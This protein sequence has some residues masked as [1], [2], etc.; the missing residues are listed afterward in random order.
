MKDD[1]IRA[2]YYWLRD[3]FWIIIKRDLKKSKNIL[4]S[5]PDI[6]SEEKT[7]LD[8]VSLKINLRDTMYVGGQ[9]KQYLSVGISA[10]RCIQEALKNKSNDFKV[11]SV[12][13]FAG[14]SGRVLRFLKV[15][16]PNADIYISEL[17]KNALKFCNKHLNVK[18]FI[19]KIH[20]NEI[21]NP[22]KFD[23]IWCG[24]LFTHIDEQHAIELLKFFYEHLSD[25]GM[26][27]FTTHGTLSIK[28][29]EEGKKN[30]YGIPVAS[31]QKIVKE[32]FSNGYGYADYP[33]EP[34]YG[35]SA[36]THHRLTEIAKSIG[37]WNEILFCE[38]GW[39]NHQDVYGFSK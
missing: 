18:S 6:T 12:L 33:N 16:F 39:D 8:N 23:L 38:H 28:W 11:N 31:Q 14:G 32:Y 4:Q 29:L 17:D 15:K 21:K 34:G 27:V 22:Q 26:C 7:L 19:S 3:F 20:F 25:K 2:V 30:T 5:S 37:N 13:D 10:I 35:I 24:S 36:V 9:G 1:I